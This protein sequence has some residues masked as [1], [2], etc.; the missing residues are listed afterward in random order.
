MLTKKKEELPGVE[1]LLIEE[2]FD[3]ERWRGLNT[4]ER[5]NYFVDDFIKNSKNSE[6]LMKMFM[7]GGFSVFNFTALLWAKHNPDTPLA[8]EINSQI[9]NFNKK[10]AKK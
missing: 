9:N 1:E 4:Q 6:E 5:Y 3:Y 8:K 7:R 2:G 10:K